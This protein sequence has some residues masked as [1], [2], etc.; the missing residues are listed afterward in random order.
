MK[1]KNRISFFPPLTFKNFCCTK[2]ADVRKHQK[3][4]SLGTQPKKDSVNV[5]VAKFERIEYDE[6]T[7][8][9]KKKTFEKKKI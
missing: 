6:G 4:P 1:K 3:P 7:K 5:L 9:K 8:K 2:I